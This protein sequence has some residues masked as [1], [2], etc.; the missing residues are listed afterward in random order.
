MHVSGG[1]DTKGPARIDRAY[2]KSHLLPL[3]R[4]IHFAVA[5]LVAALLVFNTVVH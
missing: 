2:A 4:F 1:Q 3:T 5:I